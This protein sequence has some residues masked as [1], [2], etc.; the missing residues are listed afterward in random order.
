MRV[1]EGPQAREHVINAHPVSQLSACLS[2]V[3]LILIRKTAVQG[4]WVLVSVR[5]QVW[6]GSLSCVSPPAGRQEQSDFLGPGH[7]GRLGRVRQL[8]G[9]VHDIS[10]GTFNMQTFRD[11]TLTSMKFAAISNTL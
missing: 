2:G 3:L 10:A 4:V 8:D 11:F 7:S 6:N 1:H 9:G 5:H